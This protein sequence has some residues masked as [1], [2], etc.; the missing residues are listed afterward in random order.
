MRGLV[1]GAS[2][3]SGRRARYRSK[4]TDR[5]PTG[6]S[7]E[8]DVWHGSRGPRPSLNDAL[9][10]LSSGFGAVC[11]RVHVARDTAGT[12]PPG[13]CSVRPL[14]KRESA[15][16]DGRAGLQQGTVGWFSSRG[17]DDHKG[18][19]L[20]RALS[21]G[22]LSARSLDD[23]DDDS[24]PLVA[25][26]SC[27]SL[28]SLSTSLRLHARYTRS[29]APLAR[30]L[31]RALTTTSTQTHPTTPRQSTASHAPNGPRF[32]ASR[33]PGG[34]RTALRR[35]WNDTPKKVTKIH[36]HQAIF[37]EK[38]EKRRRE[39]GQGLLG[40]DDRQRR[41]DEQ[42]HPHHAHALQRAPLSAEH[43]LEDEGQVADE[44]G[45]EEGCR[46]LGEEEGE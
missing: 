37:H 23:A 30:S 29:L 31:A 16:C 32:P 46:C 45:G 28:A 22:A 15:V 11:R 17:W 25:A 41:P 9:T 24:T 10:P 19:H 6:V 36:Q 38:K 13:V 1:V 3:T 4:T 20:G 5:R 44:E 35:P 12:L 34:N 2:L 8:P 33:P 21:L 43:G 42:P 18:A 26:P 27:L 39:E 40:N 14:D 7:V